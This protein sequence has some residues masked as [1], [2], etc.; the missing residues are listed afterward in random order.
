MKKLILISIIALLTMASCVT[1]KR[2]SRKFPPNESSKTDSIYIY[3]ELVKWKDTIIYKDLPPV[4]IE[5]YVDVKDT[6]KL[7]GNYS[8][9][10]SWVSGGKLQGRLNEGIRPV[11]IEYKIKEVEVIKEIVKTE[12]EVKIHNVK[13]IPNYIKILLT[14]GGFSALILL[15]LIFIKR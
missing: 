11:K 2:C 7:I 12:Y 14:I 8:K 13:Y 4:I 15:A 6:L 3:K 9:A 1:E 10:L 5:R